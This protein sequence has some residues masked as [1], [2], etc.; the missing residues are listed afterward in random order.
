[1]NGIPGAAPEDNN[2]PVIENGTRKGLH[3][4]S[5]AGTIRSPQQSQQGRGR[6]GRR[7]APSGDYLVT[8]TVD[9]NIFKKTV[10]IKND[11]T[12]PPSAT[13]EEELEFMKAMFGE[14]EEGSDDRPVESRID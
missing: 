9:G 13:S 1:M 4:F 5:W 12:T 8:L 10:T 6:R 14:E 2:S 11:P 3:S 7:S